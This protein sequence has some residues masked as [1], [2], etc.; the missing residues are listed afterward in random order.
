MVRKKTLAA[1]PRSLYQTQSVPRKATE[2]HDALARTPLRLAS[3]CCARTAH[4]TR[5]TAMPP[6]VTEIR[7]AGHSTISVATV[8]L[9]AHVLSVVCVYNIR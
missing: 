1:D 6:S 4:A 5:S 9:Q 2:T 8:E 7:D 3:C